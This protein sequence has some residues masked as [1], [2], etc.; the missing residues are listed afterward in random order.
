MQSKK[1]VVLACLQL[2][3]AMAVF[4][5]ASFG[6]K[7]GAT[8]SF[9]H[10]SR[11]SGPPPGGSSYYTSIEDVEGRGG[12]LIGVFT[13]IPLSRQFQLRP[14]AEIGFRSI[15]PKVSSQYGNYGYRQP[16]S[17]MDFPLP[18]TYVLQKKGSKWLIGAGPS[19]SVLLNPTYQLDILPRPMY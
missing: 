14:S 18:V 5:Q 4:G 17:Y 2:L 12:V 3:I 10:A 16:V 19:L 9:P 13:S 1:P 8:L 7:A 15:I 6:F 11:T